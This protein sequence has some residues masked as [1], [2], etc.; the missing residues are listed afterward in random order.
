[1]RSS[2]LALALC[3]TCLWT[4]F[5]TPTR[6]QIS[7]DGGGAGGGAMV[8]GQSTTTCDSA[9]DGA[10]RYNSAAKCMDFCDGTSWRSFNC[11]FCPTS[12]LVG[13]WKFEDGTGSAT[14]ADAS[15]SGHT[16]TL[17]S[18]D[19]NT[20]WVAGKIGGALD[21]DGT[22]YYVNF[23]NISGINLTATSACVW[24]KPNAASDFNHILEKGVWQEGGWVL[25]TGGSGFGSKNDPL[26][27]INSASN[28]PAG[29][30]TSA[31]LTNNTWRHVC[32]AYDGS[33]TGNA[34]RLKIYVDGV[35]QTL[36]FSGTI[37]E[38]MGAT[39]ADL[40]MAIPQHDPGNTYFKGT[41]D[42][43]RIYNRALSAAEITL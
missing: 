37:P 12:G 30:T 11:S 14:A 32:F 38:S 28:D 15:G 27:I 23:G 25:Q 16:G 10:I 21:F 13:H 42:D 40:V 33:L 7:F 24:V 31:L 20:D 5:P 36:T 8:A 17:T 4:G 1:M 18:M 43:A 3:A 19:A 41:A 29:Y 9:I 2:V 26:V 22:N 34:Q 35:Q 6:A 39:S